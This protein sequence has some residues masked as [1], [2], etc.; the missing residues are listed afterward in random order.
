MALTSIQWRKST[1]SGGSGGN[2]V[3]AGTSARE[4]HVL[5]R[6]TTDR[7]GTVLSVNQDAWRTLIAR[8]KAAK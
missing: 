3:E 4:M 6:D 1:Y 2:C 7:D 5:I 8:L